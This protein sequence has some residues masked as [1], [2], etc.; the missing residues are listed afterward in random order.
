MAAGRAGRVCASHAASSLQGGQPCSAQHFA[1][2]LFAI[3]GL[4]AYLLIVSL[5]GNA[6][7]LNSSP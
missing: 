6:D 2:A 1:L 7:A 4:N 3:S 5:Q